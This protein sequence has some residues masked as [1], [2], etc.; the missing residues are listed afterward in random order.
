[1]LGAGVRCACEL[2]SMFEFLLFFWSFSFGETKENERHV[3]RA[4]STYAFFS[5]EMIKHTDGPLTYFH[6]LLY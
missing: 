6:A 2:G 1:M 3:V 5:E 4:M